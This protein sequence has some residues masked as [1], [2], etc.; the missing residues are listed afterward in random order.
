V[1]VQFGAVN[2]EL[3]M[4]LLLLLIA[5][6]PTPKPSAEALMDFSRF[7]KATGQEVVLVDENGIALHGVLAS[8]TPDAVTMRFASGE[9]VF[10][11]TAI[12]SADRLR[13][14]NKDGFIKGAIFG[15]VLG[16]IAI[17]GYGADVRG[18]DLLAVSAVYGVLGLSV[19]A[20]VKHRH[21]I[22]RAPAAAP[23][24]KMSFRF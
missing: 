6:I 1:H 19:D 14:G 3:I 20:L 7:A 24:V 18:R 10:G 15:T 5:L 12:A 22:Y 23:S 4:G 9:R 17:E 11:K 8:A 13:D 21:P 2:E 16:L